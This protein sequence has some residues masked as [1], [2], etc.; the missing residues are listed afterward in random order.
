M[1]E[2]EGGDYR[3]AVEGGVEPSLLVWDRVRQ[4]RRVSLR[5][6][7]DLPLPLLFLCI[8]L[9]GSFNG[10]TDKTL[11]W[12]AVCAASEGVWDVIACAQSSY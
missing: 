10:N 1:K 6:S 12:S 9:V 7:Q 2:K 5:S 8:R 4:L 3:A 11:C